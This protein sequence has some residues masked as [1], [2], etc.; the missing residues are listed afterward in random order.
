MA[1][2][3]TAYTL[4]N[5]YLLEEAVALGVLKVE[6]PDRKL[7][8]R[9]QKEMLALLVIFRR[10]LGLAKTENETVIPKFKKGL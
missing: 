2:P 7:E 1:V 3:S 6:L 4:E 9:S 8:F 5:Y 10:R